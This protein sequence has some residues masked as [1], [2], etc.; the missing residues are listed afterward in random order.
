MSVWWWV[1]VWVVLVL[2]AAGVLAVLGLGLWRKAM[3]LLGELSTA[4][5]RFAEISTK[6]D[7]VAEAGQSRDREPAVFTDP[8][9]LRQERFLARRANS[10]RRGGK[11]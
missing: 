5:D 10:G 11:R 7:Q 1:L 3:A 2:A 6:L 9:E 8:L 4:S